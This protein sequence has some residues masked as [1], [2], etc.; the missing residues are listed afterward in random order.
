MTLSKSKKILILGGY[1]AVGRSLARTL[2]KETNVQVIIAGRRKEKAEEFAEILNKEFLGKRVSG[3][4][5]DSKQKETLEQAFKQINLILL[6]TTAPEDVLTIGQVALESHV[7]Y[8]DI[9][10]DQNTF[11]NLNSLEGLKK[12]KQTFITQAGFHPG[13][14]AVFIKYAATYFD[15][16]KKAIIGLAMNGKF[17]KAESAVEIVHLVGESNVD[18][19]K[20]GKW[21][22]ATLNDVKIIDFGNPFG[23]R[24]CYPMQMEELKE[25]PEK[26][27][28]E[29]TGVYVT[30]FNWFVD[31]FVFPSIL[32]AYKIKKGLGTLFFS[33]LMY[34]GVKLFS[35]DYQ[36]V[37]FTL[38][39]EGEKD[40][41][42]LKVR[43]LATHD[44]PFL[45][46]SAPVV[47]CIKQYLAGKIKPGL[48]LMGHAVNPRK[49]FEDMQKM[50]VEFTFKKE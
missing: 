35:Q 6:A 20:N 18:L 31:Y 10:V 37:T 42:L 46:T 23:V 32:L 25:L 29:E 24:K 9:L 43:I 3:L 38:D 4:Y 44:D 21:E 17:E 14:P 12:S 19:F 50:G 36:K 22:K 41:K 8:L 49:L 39:A 5:V 15:T 26:Y 30:G 7:D 28:L 45:F 40:G 48:S 13:L 1:G 2:L 16:Y 27:H 34:W 11:S 47:A 33:K